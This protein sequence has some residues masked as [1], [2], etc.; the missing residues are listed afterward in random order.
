MIFKDEDCID[1]AKNKKAIQSSISKWSQVNDA[2]R[3]C[4]DDLYI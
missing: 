1:L 4:R 2:C 3:A